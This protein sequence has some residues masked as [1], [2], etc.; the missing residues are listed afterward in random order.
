MNYNKF[1][2]YFSRNKIEDLIDRYLDKNPDKETGTYVD[3]GA[4]HAM[5]NNNTFYYYIRGWRG[6]L[7]E[8]Y[9]R[10]IAT[11]KKIRPQDILISKAIMD[12]DGKVKMN[13]NI[14][15]ELENKLSKKIKSKK[16][17]ERYIVECI[18]I[19]TLIKEHA[20]FSEPDFLSI[21]IEGSEKKALSKCDF[22]KF[23]PKII[24]IEYKTKKYKFS[25]DWKHFLLPYYELKDTLTTDAIYLRRK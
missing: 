15:Q 1:N 6:I 24:C 22:T 21:D 12:Y 2:K 23:K 7:V 19:N 8:P 17:D 3:I 16:R 9:P 5:R 10:H 4:N 11:I 20:N 14:V 13:Y 25:R 18:T